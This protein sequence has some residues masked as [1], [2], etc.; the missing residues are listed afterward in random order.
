MHVGLRQIQGQWIKDMPVKT[1]IA[2]RKQEV[3]STPWNVHNSCGPINYR[4]WKLYARKY[5]NLL[6]VL[7]AYNIVNNLSD[8]SFGF[9]IFLKYVRAYVS[10]SPV[11]DSLSFQR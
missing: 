5:L 11:I 10:L 8:L 4:H 9:Y 1:T 3:I 6:Y 2:V 7:S